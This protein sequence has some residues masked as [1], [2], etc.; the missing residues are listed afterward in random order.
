MIWFALR[1]APQKE[2][3]VKEILD[4][5]DG[6]KTRLRIEEAYCPVKTERLRVRGKRAPVVRGKALVQGY[7]FVRCAD[8]YAVLY[9]MRHRGVTGVLRRSGSDLPATISESAMHGIKICE[10]EI[11]NGKRGQKSAKGKPYAQAI[12][13]GETVSIPS[14]GFSMPNTPVNTINGDRAKVTLPFF[15]AEREVTVKVERLE[16]A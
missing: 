7:V 2:F 6:L 10:W 8:P 3:T 5:R 4:E 13:V 1:T 16:L 9:A 12:T 14:L 11:A 15:G